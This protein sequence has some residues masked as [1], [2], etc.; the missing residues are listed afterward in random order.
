MLK[1]RITK[2]CFSHEKARRFDPLSLK[3][4]CIDRT[5][6]TERS[7][8]V[9]DLITKITLLHDMIE[10]G[11]PSNLFRFEM[12]RSGSNYVSLGKG[13]TIGAALRMTFRKCEASE[14]RFNG[15]GP[16]DIFL[17]STFV[18]APCTWQSCAR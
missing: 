12:V 17:S 6:S 15:F 4:V 1:A 8:K 7:C 9:N 14:D 5:A 11:K 16:L 13:T 2:I 3:E 18:Q 10:K